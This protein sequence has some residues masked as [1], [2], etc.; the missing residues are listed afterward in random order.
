M[1]LRQQRLELENTGASKVGAATNRGLVDERTNVL[2]LD[3][4][5]RL[6]AAAQKQ[7]GSSGVTHLLKRLRAS[8]GGSITYRGRKATVSA[9]T[10]KS[11]IVAWLRQ[12]AEL[13]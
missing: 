8:V 1:G 9:E 3:E 2:T 7:A 11:A 6:I 10:L 12:D 4:I 13:T 5:M